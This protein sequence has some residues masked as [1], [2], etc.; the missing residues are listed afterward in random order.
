MDEL[1]EETDSY[2]DELDLD[3]KDIRDLLKYED[4]RGDHKYWLDKI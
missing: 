2:D 1:E 4:R 3:E